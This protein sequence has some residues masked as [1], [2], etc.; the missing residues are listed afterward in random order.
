MADLRER[1]PLPP[2]TVISEQPAPD[3]P[4]AV[5]VQRWCQA[6]RAL[7]DLTFRP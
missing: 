3:E 1:Y 7:Y 6:V 2:E 5:A 4:V